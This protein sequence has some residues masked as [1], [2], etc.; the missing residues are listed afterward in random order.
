[1]LLRDSIRKH[2]LENISVSSAGLHA[3]AG[4]P[5][6]PKITEYLSE[7]EIPFENHES[8]QLTD[9]ELEWSDLVLVMERYHLETI[10]SRWPESKAKIELLGAYIQNGTFTDDIIDPYGRSPYH[11]R[12]MQSQISLAV[13]SLTKKLVSEQDN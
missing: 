13:E 3:Y 5:G 4:N 10:I 11:Y 8:K 2:G 9:N 1:M 7:M 12:V 6:D